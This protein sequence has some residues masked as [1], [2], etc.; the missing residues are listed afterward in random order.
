[1]SSENFIGE[2]IKCDGSGYINAFGHV[3]S[4]K[5]F[6]CNGTGKISGKVAQAGAVPSEIVSRNAARD[7]WLAS[8]EKFTVAQVV[9]MFRANLTFAQIFAVHGYANESTVA[10]K[11]ARRLYVEAA[12][13]A[14]AA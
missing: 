2:C 10:W 7:A 13:E 11:A 3:V 5:C 14:V 12:D 8:F 4:G 6:L 9:A 1:M